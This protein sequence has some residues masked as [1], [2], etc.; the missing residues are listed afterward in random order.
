MIR[1]HIQRSGSRSRDS[2]GYSQYTSGIFESFGKRGATYIV[3]VHHRTK[4]V[5]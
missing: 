2:P 3:D 5:L 4:D 1:I